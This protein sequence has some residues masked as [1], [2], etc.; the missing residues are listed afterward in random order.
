[1]ILALFYY[2]GHGSIDITGGYLC[3]SEIACVDE[4]FALSD[5]MAIASSSKAKNKVIILKI[6]EY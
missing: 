2:A 6:L 4:G 5:L 1:M 3:T